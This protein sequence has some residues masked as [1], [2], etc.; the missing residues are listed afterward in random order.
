[1]KTSPP[2]GAISAAILFFFALALV[3]ADQSARPN[4]LF[5][6][7]DDLRPELNCYGATHIHSPNI[8]RLAQEGMLFSRAY[9][10]QS[11]C[12][13]SRANFLVGCRPETTG[14]DFP[15]SKYFVEDFLPNHP[16]ISGF[17]H[18][19]GY[20]AREMGKVHHGNMEWKVHERIRNELSA[21]WYIPNS[22][23]NYANPPSIAQH[24]MLQRPA[25][26]V[27]SAKV[28]DDAYRDGRIARQALAQ[29]ESL[30]RSDQP[31]FLAVGFLKPHLPFSAPK[32]YW[33]LYD[34]NAIPLSPNPSP[35]AESPSF[36]LDHRELRAYQG[37]SSTEEHAVS[38]ARQRELRHGYFACISFVDT[39]VG[40]LIE[41]LDR[42]GLREK[43]IVVFL[44]DHGF[45]LGDHG[46]WGKKTNYDHS[47]R[48]PLIISVPDMPHQGS[49]CDALVEYVDIFPTLSELAGLPTPGY[50]EGTSL[51]PLLQDPQRPWKNAVFSQFP[52]DGQEGFAVRDREWLYVE[53]RHQET[54][55]VSARELYHLPNDPN[56]SVNLASR[57]E[58][59]A[60]LSR[61]AA[62][63]EAGW[64]S[65]LP[66]GF[67]NPSNNSPAPDSS[68]WKE[69][70]Y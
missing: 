64:K 11:I 28:G 7:V 8:D 30:A 54:D 33:D 53:W 43:T 51:L 9:V 67:S 46:A 25:P 44:S 10:Q 61:L 17:F 21:P 35:A 48:A 23:L 37:E 62:K 42:L 3:K 52:R 40:Q 34:R 68:I 1:M 70:A 24:E 6:V 38:E 19:H 55:A 2:L 60:D 13:A 59:Q 50:L 29:L 26:A 16:A 36:A 5:I 12:A 69:G 4:I 14:V 58:H 31:F 66:P 63:L 22:P 56:E 49:K 32:K 27:E 45:H 57:P 18:Q 65:A 39:L 41:S 15:Y 20:F 47:T